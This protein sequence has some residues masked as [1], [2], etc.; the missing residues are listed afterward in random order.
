MAFEIVTAVIASSTALTVA[1][2]S[3]WFTKK[4]EREAELRKERL[5]HYK[6]LVS[7]LSDILE[8]D[9]N[10]QGQKRFAL[11]CNNLNLIAPVPVIKALQSFQDEIKSSNPSRTLERHDELLS[12]LLVEMRGDLNISPGGGSELMFR[13]WSPGKQ[14]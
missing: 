2:V 5:E 1:V 8:G 9:S 11:A 4:R 10:F 14:Q 6:E 7:S 13:L 12:L 3:Y